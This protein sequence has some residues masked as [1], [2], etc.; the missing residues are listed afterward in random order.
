MLGISSFSF[1]DFPDAKLEREIIKAR[2]PEISKK[3]QVQLVDFV[4]GL[5]ELDLKNY[6]TF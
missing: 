1:F 2:V 5:R 4:Q 6:K 3:L